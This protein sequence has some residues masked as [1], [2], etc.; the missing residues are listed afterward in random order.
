M[1]ATGTDSKRT[2]RAIATA[3]AACALF[4]PL[5]QAKSIH[6]GGGTP[7]K[8]DP[9]L[10]LIDIYKDLRASQLNEAQAKAD[11]LVQAYPNFRVGHLIRG[12]LLLM[13]A[14]P[15]AALGAGVPS[16]APAD[17]LQ[18]LRH[19]ARVRLQ[20]LTARPAPELAPRSVLQLRSDQKHVLVVDAAQSRLY[21]YQNQSGQLKLVTDYYITQGKLGIHKLREGDQKTP[22]GVYYITGRVAGRKLPDFYGASALRINYPN[23]WDRV[24][25]RG[26]SGIFLHGTPPDSYSRPPLASDGCVVLTNADLKK[27]E[28]TVD[29]GK[30]PVVIADKLEFVSKAKWDAERDTATRLIDSWRADISSMDRG[31]VLKNYS[32]KFKS[33]NGEDL[34]TWYDKDMRALVDV[35]GLS[36]KLSDMTLFRYPGRDDMLVS[37]FTMETLIGKNKSAIRKRQYWAREGNAWKIVF[38]GLI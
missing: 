32:A 12:D 2:T 29:I 38:E 37:T 6:P 4:A 15:V 28:G 27:L 11:A 33:S 21:V 17:R 7:S 16:N 3:V 31:R 36:V 13:H 20:A 30:T 14:Q 23:E 24:Q 5:A 8:Q 9:E 34:N 1:K 19:E 10:L 22:V 18:D 25:G 26:G 35:V